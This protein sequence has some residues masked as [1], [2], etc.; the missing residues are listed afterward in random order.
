M[1]QC[2]FVAA[3]MLVLTLPSIGCDRGAEHA[4]SEAQRATEDARR[5]ADD[6]GAERLTQ[7]LEG[8]A[9]GLATMAGDAAVDPIDFRVLQQLFPEVDGWV[10]GTPSG[11][12]MTAPIAFAQAEVV[13]TDSTNGRVEAKVVDSAFQSL[14]I[15]PVKMLLGSGFEREDEFSHQRSTEIDGSP[16]WETWDAREGEAQIT[17]IVNDRFLL[18]LEGRN[19]T[20]PDVLQQIARGIDRAKLPAAETT[21]GRE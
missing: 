16:G 4:A 6:A 19:L 20:A 5:A 2:T 17:L 3:W 14:L 21:G 1:K 18:T 9:D 15:A 12:Q 7:G 8:M 11:Q 13:Y 10:R